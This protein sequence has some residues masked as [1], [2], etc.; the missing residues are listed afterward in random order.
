MLCGSNYI[1]NT[2][3]SFKK[4]MDCHFSYVQ[5]II[6]NGKIQNHS[7]PIMIK[8]LN[9]LLQLIIYVNLLHTKWLN[10]SITLD[11]NKPNYNLCMDERL[12][13][14]KRIHDKTSQL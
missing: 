13:I 3:Q 6:K 9:V 11:K 12:M 10:I 4:I 14:L 5:L 2:H 1:G 7:L 8:T